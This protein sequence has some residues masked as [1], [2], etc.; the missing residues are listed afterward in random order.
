[1]YNKHFHIKSLYVCQVSFIRLYSFGSMFIIKRFNISSGA[2]AAGKRARP[3]LAKTHSILVSA[4]LAGSFCFLKK[5]WPIFHVM[6]RLIVLP[7]TSD[8]ISFTVVISLHHLL[9]SPE[10][11]R[12]TRGLAVDRF[13]RNSEH[14]FIA[15]TQVH[16]RCQQV[17]D[18]GKVLTE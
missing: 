7:H 13:L 1:M 2:S 17:V 4:V 9:Q 6:K 3:K 12:A 18:W 10:I 14:I 8:H 5:F 11:I 16:S 15:T